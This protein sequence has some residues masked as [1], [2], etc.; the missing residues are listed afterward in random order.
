MLLLQL[1]ANGFVNG[2]LYSLLALSYALVYNT[3]RT[4]HIAHGAVYTAGAYFSY[5]FMI[6]LDWSLAAA[7]LLAVLLSAVLGATMEL[8]VYAPLVRR[9][10]SLV[11]ALLS[12]L[13]LYVALV[14][15]IALI[16]GNETK[17]LRL[18]VDKT[19]HFGPV[20]L[21]RI[22]L[23]EVLAAVVLLPAIALLLK[24]TSLGGMIRAV[25]DNAS[26]ATV[27]GINVAGVRLWVFVLGSALAGFT[28][29]LVALDVGLH[30]QMGMPALLSGAVALIVGGV[31]TY[32]G[33]IVGGFLLGLLQSVVIWQTSVRWTDAIT[34]AVLIVFL[35]FRPWGLAGRRRRLEE[36]WE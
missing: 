4:F 17:L 18:G 5:M 9:N 11:V 23:V 25:R 20:I 8:A 21:T 1:L 29:I 32:E 10:A 14:N 26:L 6:R 28:A 35:L 16:F 33:P 19:Y 24:R 30:P 7:I 15:L 34:F 31:G 22:Q 13:G 36:T 3:T 2:C 27:M 12:S